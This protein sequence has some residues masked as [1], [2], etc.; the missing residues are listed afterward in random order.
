VKV[1]RPVWNGG[2]AER[3]YLSLQIRAWYPELELPFQLK[4]PG[5]YP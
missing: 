4:E 2:K 3:P 1:A 5:G